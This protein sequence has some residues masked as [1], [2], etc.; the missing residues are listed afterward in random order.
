MAFFL[1][2]PQRVLALSSRGFG[3]RED[4]RRERAC[5]TRFCW[6]TDPRAPSPRD[7]RP[8]PFAPRRAA[9]TA[10]SA[11][12]ATPAA[13]LGKTL[14]RGNAA[15]LTYIFGGALV[16]EMAYGSVLDGL[17]NAR[18]HGRTFAST[19]WSK[20]KVADEEAE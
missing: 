10:S 15:Y 1:R 16:L 9:S 14:F 20:W 13:A 12:A 18:N 6:R 17:W 7:P 5:S 2:A 11:S 19:D 4:E 3:E 8:S